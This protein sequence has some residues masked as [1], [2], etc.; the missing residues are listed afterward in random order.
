MN[1]ESIGEIALLVIPIVI[2][3]TFHEAAH[4][5]VAL[6]CGDRTALEQGR[7][8]LNPLKHIEPVGTVILPLLLFLTTGFMFGF[9]KPVPVNFN[10]LR[11]PRRDMTLVAA[12]GPGMNLLLAFASALLLRL[13]LLSGASES[14]VP[15]L[16]VQSVELNVPLMVFN[17]IPLPPLDGSKVVAPFLPWPVAR[18]YLS[19]ERYG[20]MI[21][22]LFLIVVPMIAERLG[23]DFDIF[24]WIV[25]IP[26]DIAT[27][28]ILSITGLT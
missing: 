16:L 1:I 20:T 25:R 8:T 9:A 12:A 7:I 6:M 11:N 13:Y 3:I 18:R 17:L 10:A 24:R 15:N 27:R 22:L 26:S 19:L 21:L 5:Y 14:F 28:F 23:S 2:A 4:G